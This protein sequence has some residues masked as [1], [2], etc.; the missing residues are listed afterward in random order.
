MKLIPYSSLLVSTCLSASIALA[1]N[2]AEEI[3][4]VANRIEQSSNSV[5]AATTVIDKDSIRRSFAQN[6]AELLA[7]VPGMQF[8]QS[9]G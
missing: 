1:Q 2:D 8:S 7:V 9:G 4:V 3:L 5:M 6:L